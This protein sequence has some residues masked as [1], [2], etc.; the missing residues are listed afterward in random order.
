MFIGKWIKSAVPC[1]FP[2]GKR[3]KSVCDCNIA[4]LFGIPRDKKVYTKGKKNCTEIITDPDNH[5]E[6]PFNT[7]STIWLYSIE[8]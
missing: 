5:N 2:S 7:F 3:N 1:E 6:H 4:C 8:L